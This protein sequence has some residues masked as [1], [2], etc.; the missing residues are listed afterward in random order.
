[1]KT[2]PTPTFGD[3]K[4]AVAPNPKY[5]ATAYSRGLS[6]ND[7][8]QQAYLAAIRYTHTLS[9][10]PAELPLPE[11]AT[12]R[13]LTRK[14]TQG[15]HALWI[16]TTHPAYDAYIKQGLLQ[17]GVPESLITTFSN[18]PDEAVLDETA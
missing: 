17:A 1:M 9:S 5:E 10:Y 12:T 15:K 3:L 11:G 2:K 4:I 13:F 7:K 16:E 18:T 14:V 8:A 6:K